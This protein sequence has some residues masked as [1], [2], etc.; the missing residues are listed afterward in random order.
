MEMTNWITTNV[1]R[2]L[3]A[4]RPVDKAPFNVKIGLVD[5][6]YIA[7]KIAAIKPK[8]PEP[9][10]RKNIVFVFNNFP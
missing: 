1:S 8:N 2:N 4:F 3:V 6:K 7:G 9:I 5:V 10:K